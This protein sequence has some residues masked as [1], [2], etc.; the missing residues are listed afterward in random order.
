MR[1]VSLL[2]IVQPE[3]S[4]GA[5][6]A[7]QYARWLILAWQTEAH[8]RQSCQPQISSFRARIFQRTC[9]LFSTML[10]STG[11]QQAPIGCQSGA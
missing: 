1:G 3:R 8:F 5:G 7:S 10:S 9:L 4:V 2:N 11:A 6:Q